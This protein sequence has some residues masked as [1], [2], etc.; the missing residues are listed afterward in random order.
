MV[1]DTTSIESLRLTAGRLLIRDHPL[2]Y[3]IGNIRQRVVCTP[4]R[5]LHR[6]RDLKMIRG[7]RLPR[8][9]RFLSLPMIVQTPGLQLLT[10]IQSLRYRVEEMWSAI[11][12]GPENLGFKSSSDGMAKRL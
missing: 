9:Y 3:L 1:R 2:I 11:Q 12:E 5:H 7:R 6:V 8:L 4:P 10:P